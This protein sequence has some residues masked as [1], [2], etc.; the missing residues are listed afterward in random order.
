DAKTIRAK[1]ERRLSKFGLQLHRDKTRILRFGRFARE[2]NT[3][4]GLKTETFDFLGFTH[5]V[6]RDGKNGWFQLR[7]LTSRKKRQRTLAEL[8]QQLRRR[9]HE[10]A[11]ETHAWLTSVLRGHYQYFG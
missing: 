9:R 1:L 6:S 2:R 8:Y 11:R 7:R 5:V 10:D 3:N 4:L